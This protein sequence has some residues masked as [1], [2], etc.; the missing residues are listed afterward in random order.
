MALPSDLSTVTIAGTYLDASGAGL[1]G[2]ITFT[3]SG[4]LTDTTGTTVIPAFGKKYSVAA[5]GKFTTDPLVA[6]DNAD[7]LGSWSY[8]VTLALQNLPTTTWNVELPA[9]PFSFTATNATPCVFTATGSAYANGT[10]VKLGGLSLPTGFTAGTTYFVVSASG[11]SFSLAATSG[12]SAIASTST[13]SGT[14][15]TASSDISSLTPVFTQLAALQFAQLLLPTSVQSGSITA[16]AG[17]LVLVTTAS[18]NAT[19]SLPTGV[20]AGS[21][22]GVKMVVLGGSNT[23][24]IACTGSDKLNIAGGPTTLSLSMLNQGA[25][26]V[27][28]G[29]LW[30]IEGDDIPLAGLDAR[31]MANL[32]QT[33]VKTANYTAAANE[34][35]RCDTSGGSFTVTLPTAPVAG[36]LAGVKQVAVAGVGTNAVTVACGGSDIFNVSGGAASATLT[37]KG[38]SQLL[39]YASGVWEV[40]A[41]DDAATSL[42]VSRQGTWYLDSFTGTDDA[43]MTAA[44]TA[45][46][47]ASPAGGT[48]QLSPRA[49]TFANQWATTYSAGVA[50]ALKIQGAGVGFNGAWGTPTAATTATFT[51]S[52]VGAGCIDMQHI[53][54]VE[55]SGIKL[56]SANVGVPL[57]FTTNATPNIHD[58]VF[59][60]GGNGATCATDA[61]VLGGTGQTV[62]AGDTAP[63]QG[64]QGAIYRNFFD[65][66]RR[67]VVWQVFANSAQAWGNSISS[68]CGSNLFQGAP[69]ELTGLSG[70]FCSGNQIWNNVIE[71]VHYTYAVKAHFAGDNTFGPNGLFDMSTAWVAGY[72][73]DSS[74]SGNEII[75]GCR[76]TVTKPLVIDVAGGGNNRQ[77][78]M[79]RGPGQFEGFHQAVGFYPNAQAPQSFFFGQ[80]VA[81]VDN[82]GNQGYWRT[83]A[84][85]GN[86]PILQAT[87]VA[88]AQ[89]TDGNLVT[90]SKWV[91]SLTAAFALADTGQAIGG[92]GIPSITQITYTVTTST[93]FAWQASFAYSLG[94]IIRPTSAN[95][96]LYQATVG[97]TSGSSAPTFP[98]GGGTVADGAVTWQDLGAA[99]AALL[100]NSATATN[101]GVTISLSRSSGT[102]LS[103]TAFSRHH[104]LSSGTAPTV[105]AGS[106]A[107]VGTGATATITG[108]DLCHN[109]TLNTGT[110]SLAAGLLATVTFNIAYT[111]ATKIMLTPKNT[112]SAAVTIFCGSAL[113]SWTLSSN[114][115]L[116]ASTTYVW[117]VMS[118]Q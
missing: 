44:L 61:V 55:I 3:P 98:T 31:Y 12:G 7:I 68:N 24:T 19:V 72:Y 2:T 76:T 21:Q 109:L 35:V 4:Q 81:G 75:D 10:P 118:M 74:S 14:V 60:G 108:N 56:A 37:L 80:S 33:A 79:Q 105:A 38:Q 15:S 25:L 87:T 77:R 65:G 52:G 50:T 9:A 91:S 58:N 88:S 85:A 6:T 112:A 117:D 95:A 17:Q 11:T 29:S 20:E 100:T 107:Q 22:V 104:I 73:L 30:V 115:A 69:F 89:F 41:T 97:G 84:G 18:G 42:A 101:T 27:Y 34:L 82:F 78:N 113:A 67:A 40:V 53:G 47:A 26:L 39:E 8:L 48:I 5:S 59:S 90:G 102:T 32:V 70:S 64:Y 1:P 83:N 71:C 86:I 103:M 63:Y 13:G 57:F 28:T 51:Y 66:I 110:G 106:S 16:A 92:T 45:L 43:K 62:G 94:D 49:H 116:A 36:T 99:T 114:T 46:F 23:V 54:T 96:H 93:A 111:G